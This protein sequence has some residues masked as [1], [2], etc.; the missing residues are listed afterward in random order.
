[1]ALDLPPDVTLPEAVAQNQRAGH[2]DGI[3][4]IEADGT[5]V[6]TEAARAAVADLDPRLAEPLRLDDL[7]AR[8]AILMETLEPLRTEV[9]SA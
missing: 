5:V 3:E 9:G 7:E 4:T 6:F 2:Q 8:A 1:V